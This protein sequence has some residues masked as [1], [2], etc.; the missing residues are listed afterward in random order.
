MSTVA[1]IPVRGGS[2][3]ICRKNIRQLAG[4][5]LVHWTIQAALGAESIDRVYVASEDLQIRQVA[6]EISHP[7]LRVISRSAHT[8]TN[9]ASTE[10][11][12]LEFAEAHEFEKVVLVQATSPLLTSQDIEEGI[13]RMVQAGADSLLSVNREHR[14]R[15][16]TTHTG[17][18]FADNYHPQARPRRQ[19]W[20][21]ELVENG[22]FYI[23]S[24][25]ALLQSRCRV[26]GNI[27][28]F[29]MPN[30]SSL[31]L[32]E[33]YQWEVAEM[34]LRRRGMDPGFNQRAT[35]IELL[36]LDVDGVLTEGGMYYDINGEALK[37]FHTR[38]GH[39]LALWREKGLE[40]VLMTGERTAM[41]RRRA[42]KLGIDTVFLGVKDKA[43]V[44]EQL[45]AQRGLGFESVAAIGDDLG[46]LEAL[47]LAG[48]SAC[49]ADAIPAV[50]SAV[51][52]VCERSGGEGCVRE[53]V[54]AIL[55][56]REQA[57]LNERECA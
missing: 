27:A 34:L 7:K 48:V 15:W 31:E 8:A 56:A 46:D 37:R 57:A 32:D 42:E 47:S 35:Q 2:V 24:R 29:E 16:R 12:L 25:A 52:Y 40:I 49:P 19:D 26:S 20:D 1:F 5:P 39:G 53:F 17:L 41:A 51:H 50:R 18:V 6:S 4:R 36:L 10:S 13:G 28:A 38:D 54:D 33:P 14:F 55:Q 9:A 23:T 45:L 21:G 11:A 3:S 44:L 22:A 43:S 30:Q